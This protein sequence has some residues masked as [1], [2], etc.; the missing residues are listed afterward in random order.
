MYNLVSCI[1]GKCKK[2]T[3]VNSIS[4]DG[5]IN[6]S[7][8]LVNHWPSYNG[9]SHSTVCTM[10]ACIIVFIQYFLTHQ[11]LNV[12]FNSSSYPVVQ[13]SLNQTLPISFNHHCHH[14]PFR[15]FLHHFQLLKQRLH[16]VQWCFPKRPDCGPFFVPPSLIFINMIP[17]MMYNIKRG[18]NQFDWKMTTECIDA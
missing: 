4:G 13:R 17:L 16:L 14:Y 2:Q 11:V 1:A 18:K 9:P 6:Q 5:V 8:L 3:I 15:L 12:G 7:G 10:Y